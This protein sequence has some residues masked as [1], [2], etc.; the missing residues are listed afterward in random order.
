M[1]LEENQFN[2]LEKR[3]YSLK[4]M[5]GVYNSKTAKFLSQEKFPKS[6]QTYPEEIITLGNTIE[7]HS[8]LN[9]LNNSLGRRRTWVT[10]SIGADYKEKIANGHFSESHANSSATNPYVEL[11]T[12]PLS[13]VQQS[14][15]QFYTCFAAT[16]SDFSGNGSLYQKTWKVNPNFEFNYNNLAA[17]QSFILKNFLPPSKYGAAYGASLYQSDSTTAPTTHAAPNFSLGVI[18]PIGLTNRDEGWI[19]DYKEGCLLIASSGPKSELDTNNDGGYT[20]YNTDGNTSDDGVDPNSFP[21]G[22]YNATF[23]HPLYITAYRYFGPTGF[24]GVD[25]PITA[26]SIQTIGDLDVGGNITFSE[27]FTFS[28]LDAIH[29]TGSNIFGDDTSDTH[30]FTGSVSISGSFLVNGSETIGTGGGGGTAGINPILITN[31]SSLLKFTEYLTNRDFYKKN[32]VTSTDN[33]DIVEYIFDKGLFISASEGATNYIMPLGSASLGPNSDNAFLPPNRVVG[34]IDTDDRISTLVSSIANES[35]NFN[36]NIEDGVSTTDLFRFSSSLTTQD[37]PDLLSYGKFPAYTSS[38]TTHSFG[39]SSSK[40]ISKLGLYYSNNSSDNPQTDTNF[41]YIEHIILKGSND[42]ATYENI[43]TESG[44]NK[45]RTDGHI[46]FKQYTVGTDPEYTLHGSNEESALSNGDTK[47]VLNY[48]SSEFYTDSFN[49]GFKHYRLFISGGVRNTVGDNYY[50]DQ[51]LHHIDLYENL[52]FVSGNRKQITIGFDNSKDPLQPNYSNFDIRI[53][54]SF[55]KLG[56]ASIPEPEAAFFYLGLAQNSPD[57]NGFNA[58]NINQLSASLISSSNISN[59]ENITTKFL[60]SSTINTDVLRVSQSLNNEGYLKVSKSIFLTNEMDDVSMGGFPSSSIVLQSL[61]PIYFTN[62]TV[63]NTIGVDQHSGRIFGHS[64]GDVNNLYIDGYR[65]FN[66]ADTEIRLKTHHPTLGKVVVSASRGLQVSG[67]ISSSGGILATE[68]IYAPNFFDLSGN[69]IAGGAGFPFNGDAQLT[70][71][72]IISQSTTGNNPHIQLFPI[73]NEET[74]INTAN[75]DAGNILWNRN[76]SLYWGTVALASPEDVGDTLTNAII[77]TSLTSSGNSLFGETSTFN[78]NITASGNI[79]ASGLLF[80][81]TSNASGNPYSTVLIDIESG[82]FYY[83]GS[84]GGGGE[85]VSSYTDLSNIPSDIISSSAQIDASISGAFY[86]DSSSFS[87]RIGELELGGG[88]GDLDWEIGATYLSSSMEIRVLGDI[89]SS[90]DHILQDT[91][92][93]YLGSDSTSDTPSFIT[94][95]NNQ[96]KIEAGNQLTINAGS[97]SPRMVISS[98]GNVGIGDESPT[99][100]PQSNIMLSLRGNLSASRHV[101]F[102]GLTTKNIDQIILWDKGTGQLHVTGANSLSSTNVIDPDET[103]DFDII[104]TNHL[105]ITAS[106]KTKEDA[107]IDGGRAILGLSG[108]IKQQYN[109]EK[110]TNYFNTNQSRYSLYVRNGVTVIGGDIIPDAPSQ[111]SLG[112]KEFPFKDLHL[113][114]S[115]IFFYS[116]SSETSGSAKH[117]IGKISINSSSKVVEFR[118][119]SGFQSIQVRE[120]NIG[121]TT[122]GSTPTSS[123]QISGEGQGFVAV[124]A[125]A[126]KHST[127]F[128]AE[129]PQLTGDLRMGSITQKGSGS[130]AILLDADQVRGDAKLGVYSN[131]AI[132]GANTPLLTTSESGETRVYDYFKADNYITT[133]NITASNNISASGNII[134]GGDIISKG[135]IISRGNVVAQNYIISSSITHLTQSFSSGSTIFGNSL[136]D[137]HQ[138]TGSIKTLG[139]ITATSFSGNGS[140]LTGFTNITASGNISSSGI[141]TSDKVHTSFLQINK[142]N[143]THVGQGNSF[144]FSPG[145]GINTFMSLNAELGS[146]LIRPEHSGFGNTV[147]SITQKGSGSFEILLDADNFHA[148]K[149]YFGIR[150]N[151]PLPGTIGNVLFTVSESGETRAYN[152]LK[153]DSHITASGNISGSYT[154]TASFGSL[155][156]NNLPTTPTGLPTGSVWISGSKNDVS[157]SNIN[158][159]TLMIVI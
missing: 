44:I 156:L 150:T 39:F 94:H 3:I 52:K 105:F 80:A 97:S 120:I 81:S 53:S 139:G 23:I 78:G 121:T 110:I 43:Y 4:G 49:T 159:G 145:G 17:S 64:D 8:D 11:I 152:T 135:N 98:E 154:T 77:N 55:G 134:I 100:G 72:L 88:G 118:S 40:I 125:E 132:P 157:T 111:H 42:G 85:G 51:W 90:G 66:I 16:G 41:Q 103:Y 129:H 99:L 116:G 31:S 62:R 29:A 76:G 48:T 1:A 27:G 144:Y 59:G 50:Y 124:H 15:G 131:T 153:V 20:D 126:G 14:A 65:L 146:T 2:E 115:T 137:I 102:P 140:E 143:Y 22:A 108:S 86:A 93:I 136:D 113:D 95:E 21:D 87:T 38:Y 107:F 5:A 128:R 70:G 9:D 61:N 114:K 96:L 45:A 13:R 19:F 106:I 74:T 155:Q 119:G 58:Q 7:F 138:F 18:S 83:T 117:E 57:F 130:F 92:R 149:P 71:S 147:G 56:V 89:S 112:S 36:K 6:P 28:S 79:S 69:E 151:S 104:N 133:T 32:T 82:Q 30:Q 54:E 75:E 158:C 26:S 123:V 67:G 101:Y 46:P 141:I 10:G 122:S 127:I 68:P 34:D 33:N 60:S 12:I 142:G 63:N 35:F 37:Y 73:L 24:S 25:I 148:G 109:E 84:Y 47:Y 91:K